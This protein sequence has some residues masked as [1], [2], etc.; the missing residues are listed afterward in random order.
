M[1][2]SIGIMSQ[3]SDVTTQIYPETLQNWLL[4]NNLGEFSSFDAVPI[5]CGGNILFFILKDICIICFF[6]FCFQGILLLL[7]KIK[8]VLI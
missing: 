5:I 1:H 3:K 7:S 2:A 4:M 6:F 8:K